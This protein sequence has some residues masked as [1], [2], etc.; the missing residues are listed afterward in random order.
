MNSET[1]SGS[2]IPFSGGMSP[3]MYAIQQNWST[4]M[5]AGNFLIDTMIQLV[6]L[7][8]VTYLTEKVKKLCDEI[9]F[10]V[11]TGYRFTKRFV[12]N[13]YHKLNKTKFKHEISREIPYITDKK[14]INE[15]FSAVA[16]YLS[17]A[18]EIDFN[19]ELY[20]QL[21]SEKRI[22]PNHIKSEYQINKILGQRV[23]KKI[24][25]GDHDIQYQLDTELVTVFGDKEKKKENFK[26]LLKAD[27]Y[28]DAKNDILFEFTQYC[29]K[30][31]AESLSDGQWEQ[32]LYINKNGKWE[33]TKSN[34]KRKMSTIFLA[35]DIQDK[36]V[37]DLESFVTSEQWYVENDVPYRRG[38]FLNGPTG[39]G[40]TSIIK[41]ASLMFK[42]H[43]HYL[44]LNEIKSDSELFDL[45]KSIKFDETVLVIEDIDCMADVTKS[46][47]TKQDNNDLIETTCEKDNDVM[48]VLQTTQNLLIKSMLDKD[49]TELNRNQRVQMFGEENN[50]QGITL[51]GLLNALDG[52]LDCH[53]RI[54]FMTTNHKEVLDTAL[55]RP[56][57]C[58]IEYKI[59][60]CGVK[61]IEKM[62]KSFFK[63]DP[64]PEQLDKLKGN[65]YSGARISGT[66]IKYRSVPDEALDH[67]NDE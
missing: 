8:M 34:Q 27:V 12:A 14:T 36:L 61:E 50:N 51:S 3:S 48:K 44:M 49:K 1:L 31:Y 32:M 64:N 9:I 60:N 10:Y 18:S 38:Y 5:K 25:F 6:V 33:G 43:L 63:K 55:I 13:S 67:I 16:W 45:F 37:S 41:A 65:T 22:I 17:T 35:G 59:E 30:K 24:K 11:E 7:A 20:L 47:A 39:N 26:I 40:K 19:G 42:R 15:I 58:D 29:I 53:G 23:N 52:L 62:F 46:R 2:S 57:R 28:P 66:L 21:T 4:Y 54:I 56:G